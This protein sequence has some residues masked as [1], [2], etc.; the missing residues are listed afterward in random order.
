MFF[1]MGFLYFRGVWY[2]DKY[3]DDV[4]RVFFRGSI[5][6]RGK[7]GFLDVVNDF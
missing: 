1:L 4:M 2:L 7:F 6:Y 5:F 3:I